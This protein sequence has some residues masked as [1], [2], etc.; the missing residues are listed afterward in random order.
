MEPLEVVDQLFS[1][2]PPRQAWH[3]PDLAAHKRTL[4]KPEFIIPIPGWVALG[5]GVGSAIPADRDVKWFRNRPIP[6][7]AKYDPSI[8]STKVKSEKQSGS[9]ARVRVTDDNAFT[10]PEQVSLLCNVSNF[11]FTSLPFLFFVAVDT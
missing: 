2:L 9:K 1:Q 6:A 5:D 10:S 4:V 7:D 3:H 8:H 11:T